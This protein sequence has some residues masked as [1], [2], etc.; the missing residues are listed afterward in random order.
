MVKGI[1][2]I[3]EPQFKRKHKVTIWRDETKIDVAEFSEN[4]WRKDAVWKKF[5]NLLNKHGYEWEK[6]EDQIKLMIE[7]QFTEQKETKEVLIKKYPKKTLEEVQK[8]IEKWLYIEDPSDIKIILGCTLDRRIKGEPIWVFLVGPPGNTKTEIIRSLEDG[9]MFYQL[10]TLTSNSM[11]SGYVKPDGEKVKDLAEQ[12]NNK[13]LVIKDFT[14]ILT[15]NRDKREEIIGQLRD[16]YD[17]YINRKLGNIDNKIEHKTSFGIIAG[18]TPVIDKHY[19]IMGQLGERFLKMRV[20]YDDDKIINQADSNEGKEKEM[21]EEITSLIMGFLTNLELNENINF[22][23]QHKNTIKLLAK[24]VA[25]LRTP[26]SSQFV[27]DEIV[28][29]IK[30]Q[31]EKPTRIYKQ[32]K[33]LATC[34]CNITGKDSFDN[35]IYEMLKRV[36]RDTCPQDRLMVLDFFNENDERFYENDLVKRLR[37]PRTSLQRLLWALYRLEMLDRETEKDEYGNFKVYWSLVPEQTIMGVYS[38]SILG[39]VE[40]PALEEREGIAVC[41]SLNEPYPQKEIDPKGVLNKEIEELILTQI[42]AKGFYDASELITN[43]SQY[44]KTT[45]QEIDQV[46]SRLKKRGVL[47]EDWGVLKE[48]K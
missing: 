38:T 30:P 27:G 33:K 36:S 3:V 44:L 2:F 26:I 8:G 21:R 18:V 16:A 47:K 34:L 13:I 11:I 42:R 22:T 48:I 10:S 9:T 39:Q 14:S 20:N 28:V 37:M 23:E 45:E 19:K 15:M 1:L 41:N 29:D 40:P 32:L 46:I 6:T 5:V 12:L 7:L 25:K 4:F 35:E 24:F 17:G 31:S 43:L